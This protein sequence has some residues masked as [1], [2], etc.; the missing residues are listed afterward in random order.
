M[1]PT[2]PFSWRA[3]FRGLSEPGPPPT[4]LPG[5]AFILL[6]LCLAAVIIL[7]QLGH[8]WH[9]DPHRFFGER[10]AGT[11]LSFFN[12]VATG[13]VAASIAR[14]LRGKPFARFWWAAA[15]GFV[16]LGCDDLFVVHER[17]DRGIHA[18]LGLDPEH[19]VTD[20]LDDAIVALYGVAALVL[21]YA[22]RAHLV[23][24]RWMILILALAFPLFAWMVVADVLHLS[25]T[26]EDVLKVV[27][28]SLILVG[29]LAAWLQLALPGDQP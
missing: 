21:A 17:L 26:L 6:A 14:R 4:A 11:Y 5:V 23:V 8:A 24:L 15:V 19:P 16:W 22:H 7:V 3:V 20:H 1:S 18:V 12:L 25:K 10:K 2:P 9:D 27:A 28:G 29:F 13:V